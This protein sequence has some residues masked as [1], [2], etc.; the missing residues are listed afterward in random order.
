MVGGI[1]TEGAF[2]IEL[3]SSDAETQKHQVEAEDISGEIPIDFKE[4]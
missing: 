2:A 1:F 3:C 4:K